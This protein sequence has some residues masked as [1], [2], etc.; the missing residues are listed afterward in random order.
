MVLSSEVPRNLLRNLKI[1]N[2]HLTFYRWLSK[3]GIWALVWPFLALRETSIDDS[4]SSSKLRSYARRLE[5][6]KRQYLSKIICRKETTEPKKK[7][8]NRTYN[9]RSNCQKH[10]REKQVYTI[11][12]RLWNG[13]G[14]NP[15]KQRNNASFRNYMVCWGKVKLSTAKKFGKK[16]T[17]V[18]GNLLNYKIPKNVI[19]T[20]F[21][22]NAKCN[23]PSLNWCWICY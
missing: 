5:N 11:K 13:G 14:G 15:E 3:V 10:I 1:S 4:W 18:L 6:Y 8:N 2:C 21:A 7:T 16:N 12:V 22:E 23:K 17:A 9:V 20:I 19:M